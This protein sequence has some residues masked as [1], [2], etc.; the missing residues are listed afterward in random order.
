ML[1]R[2]AYPWHNM[3]S[4]GHLE[5][6]RLMNWCLLAGSE[7][8]LNS[9]EGIV[10]DILP[11]VGCIVVTTRIVVSRIDTSARI[12]PTLLQRPTFATHLKLQCCCKGRDARVG[13]CVMGS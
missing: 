1:Q 5:V 8:V 3:V 6:Q 9:N 4:S 7:R 12:E 10:G 11:H 13:L 2:V